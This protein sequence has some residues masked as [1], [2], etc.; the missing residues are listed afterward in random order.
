MQKLFEGGRNNVL[1]ENF[2]FVSVEATLFHGVGGVWPQKSFA[3]FHS[4]VCNFSAFCN[5]F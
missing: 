1:L 3:K 5:R 2:C 4:N